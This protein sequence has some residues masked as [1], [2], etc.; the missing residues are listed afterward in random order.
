MTDTF[1]AVFAT[2]A[3]RKAALDRGEDSDSRT[4]KLL[5]KGMPE[6]A[7]KLG[8]EATETVIEA[9][10]GNRALLIE[11]SADLMFHLMVLWAASDLSPDDIRAELAKRHGLPETDERAYRRETKQKPA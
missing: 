4:Q 6:I 3:A 5:R 11:E 10:Q 1:D 9:V 8:E 2:I 7:K